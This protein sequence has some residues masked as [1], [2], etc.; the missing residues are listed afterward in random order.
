MPAHSVTS[1]D[2]A[3]PAN[4]VTSDTAPAAPYWSAKANAVAPN[5]GPFAGLRV[6]SAGSLV[7]APHAAA[8]LADFGAEFIHIERPG[9]GDT[10]RFMPPFADENGQKVSTT[11]LQEGRNRLSLTLELNLNIPEVKETFFDLVRRSDIFME[12]MVWLDKLAI[13][14]E[15]LL[16]V[17]PRLVIAHVSG[18]G[19]KEFGGLPEYCDMAS[20]DLIGQAFSG[21]MHLNGDPA[22]SVP[23]LTKPWTSDYISGFTCLFGV[24]AAY[25]EVLK[26]G[27]GQV[28][29]V[30]Q[31]EANARI[32]ADTFCTWTEAGVL[33][34]R[35][36]TKS[37]AFQPFGVYLDRD[38]DYVAIGA[39]GKAVYER[40]IKAVGWDLE[41]FSHKEAGDGV[42][43]LLSPKGRELDAKIIAWCAERTAD[44]IVAALAPARVGVAKVNTA[45]DC[46]EHPHYLR[47]H[48][49][50]RYT[51][52]T[53]GADVTAFGI[54][55]KLSATPGQVWR[56]SPALGQ[57]T[58]AI[59]TNVCGYGPDKIAA[60]RQKGVI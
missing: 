57:D 14:D 22:P 25:F 10:W 13:H 54:A 17:N 3:L 11:W 35:N 39:F 47:R 44:E 42:D 41:Y 52:Q 45:R 31:F 53:T 51:D 21:F 28:V 37:A 9:V 5:F 16:E 24:L 2:D 33:R 4:T 48:D 60:L 29:D 32:L 15:E 23:G 55:P 7:A 56:G 1:A 12:N 18:F 34:A 43:T 50:V 8:M 59:L 19:R 6:L 20:Y 30:A 36:G 38:G 58:D 49:F 40:F 46:V 26:T 27:K